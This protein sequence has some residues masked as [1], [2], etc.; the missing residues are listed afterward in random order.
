MDFAYALDAVY[1]PKKMSMRNVHTP[2]AV[3]LVNSNP[4]FRLLFQ[5]QSNYILQ[6]HPTPSQ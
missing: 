6:R 1:K 4:N 2:D 5:N 3:I